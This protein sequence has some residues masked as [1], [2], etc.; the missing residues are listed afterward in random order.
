MKGHV[1]MANV[2]PDCISNPEHGYS[3]RLSPR[4]REWCPHHDHDMPKA[5]SAFLD[6]QRAANTEAEADTAK[7]G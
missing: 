6:K 4:D 5:P 7:A 2:G 1:A 3:L